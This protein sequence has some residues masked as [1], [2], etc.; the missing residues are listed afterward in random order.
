[1]ERRL[2][3]AVA[4]AVLV[5]V[6]A[7]CATDDTPPDA[8]SGSSAGDEAGEA[9]QEPDATG[10]PAPEGDEDVQDDDPAL[11]GPA[12]PA[13]MLELADG[14]VFDVTAEER[15]TFLVFWAEW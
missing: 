12:A 5:V 1:M 8:G 6:A 10:E 4:L 3:V 15:V 2:R 7:G 9:P 13:F 11:E 14:G